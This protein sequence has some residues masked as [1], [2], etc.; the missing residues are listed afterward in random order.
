VLEAAPLIGELLA[1]CP[2]LKVLATSRSVLRVYGEREY[3]VPAMGLPDSG[4][5]PPV[6]R[7]T[8]YEAVRLFV[9]RASSVKGDFEITGENA[10]AV[11]E[12]CVR[13]D[14]LPLAIELAAA[15][16][17][18][19]PPGTIAARLEDNRLKL[20]SSGARD[21]PERQQTLR[22]AID[23]SHALLE[24]GDK[25]LFARLA[26]FSGGC[27]LE[28]MET[29][30]D[31]E[32]ALER[33][34]SLLDKSLIRQEGDAHRFVMLETIHEYARERLGERGDAE[35]TRLRH[36]E[37]FLTLAEDSEPRLGGPSR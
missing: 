24:E 8:R 31:Q 32:D 30:C 14:G 5:L 10:P 35:T 3:A 6:E 34:E 21:L 22:G 17:K 33:A 26:V 23:W 16:I 36:A 29:I 20:L 9:E 19:L 15:R 25:V 12:I 2:T 37:Y 11:A 27:T 18:M 4:S 28:A 1:A 13:L 7:L